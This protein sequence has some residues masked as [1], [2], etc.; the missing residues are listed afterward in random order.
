MAIAFAI[1]YVTG[2][3]WR[4]IHITAGYAASAIIAARVVW[5]FIGSR[6]ARFDHFVRSPG[7][8]YA[9]LRDVLHGRERRYLGRGTILRQ[10]DDRRSAG[11]SPSDWGYWNSSYDRLLLGF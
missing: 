6:Y 5:G 3:G 9:Y 4:S 10:S 2:E 1:A 8:G 11:P 7:A